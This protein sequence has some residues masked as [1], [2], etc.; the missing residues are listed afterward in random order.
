MVRGPP[1]RVSSVAAILQEAAPPFANRVFVQPQLGRDGL[2]GHAL[3]DYCRGLHIRGIS[4]RTDCNTRS[5]RLCDLGDR[6]AFQVDLK[7]RPGFWS[8]KI[9]GEI[10][11][12]W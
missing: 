9:S 5:G 8:P 1:E 2:A 3:D 11:A 10:E 12:I 7:R 6:A 4:A